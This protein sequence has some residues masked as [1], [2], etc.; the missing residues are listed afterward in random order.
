MHNEYFAT[1]RSLNI[2][3]WHNLSNIMEIFVIHVII[4][5]KFQRPILG[6]FDHFDA[7]WPVDLMEM[8]A[9]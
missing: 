2:G 1:D 3:F 4:F 9:V 7:T 5:Q 8:E 6:S